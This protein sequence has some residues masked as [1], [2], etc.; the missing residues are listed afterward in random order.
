M[1]DFSELEDR[2]ARVAVEYAANIQPDQVVIVN[3]DYGQHGLARAVARHAYRRGA[4]FVDV[5]YFDPH[6]KR[7][8]IEH[9]AEETLDYVPP[10]YGQRVLEVDELAGARISLSGSTSPGL[11][12]DLAPRRLSRDLLPRVKE[13]FEVI[14]RGRVN[15]L[16]LPG[17]TEGWARQ[18]FPDDPEPLARLWEQI[19]HVCRLDEND[20][21]EAW[22]ERF[23]VTADVGARLT[24]LRLDAV[25]FEGPGTDL[26]VGLFPSSLW[27]NARDRTKRGVEFVANLPSEE[28]T[29]TPD[30]ARTEGVVRST[31]PLVL[32]DGTLI[33]GIE[34]RFEEGRAV[35]VEA[36]TGGDA[37]QG[38]TSMDE[39]A[40]RLGE[41]AL[42][43]RD[44]RI[45]PLGTVFYDT[46]IDENAASHLAFGGAYE[47]LVGEEDVGKINRSGLHLDFMIG[48]DEV[49]VTGIAADGT[50]VPV[51][52]GGT[53]QV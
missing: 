37:L 10:W 28:L 25:H 51:L 26:T 47:S 14:N 48:S 44:G 50:R 41:V 39:G 3:C 19:A 4:R 46:L 34:V 8:R 16:V 20:P 38:R 45:G 13:S 17:P 53:W 40:R 12:D 36:E 31:R 1:T 49:D 6:L 42:V 7:A 52:R 23:A 9:A 32:S 5:Q 33:D 35:S 29:A 15:W 24:A 2:L 22:R 18:V 43:D 27:E 11:L 30:P 21:V